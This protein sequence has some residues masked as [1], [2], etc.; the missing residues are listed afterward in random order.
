MI[1]L[2]ALASYLWGSIPWGLLIGRWHRGIDLREHGSG[3]IGLTNAL[4]FLGWKATAL[5]FIGDAAKGVVAILLA[6][7]LVG[8]PTSQ[9]V[10]ALAAIAGH[11]FSIFL[12]FKGGRGVTTSVAALAMFFP[13]VAALCVVLFLVVVA[14][15]RYVSLGSLM[16][17]ALSLALVVAYYL[18][19]MA[20]APHVWFVG[21]GAPLIWF[22]HRGNIGRLLQGKE[23]RLGKP[24]KA[25]SL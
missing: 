7:W 20:V 10:A 24:V 4:R 16:G 6:R 23:R 13:G 8:T 9:V 3:N 25:A 2:L 14:L 21:I 18:W 17:A 12:K 19:G 1:V 5:V 15:T 22:Q 11:D